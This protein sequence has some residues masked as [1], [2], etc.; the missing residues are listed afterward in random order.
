MP[1]PP[2]PPTPSSSVDPARSLGDP[3]P[4]PGGELTTLLL[5]VLRNVNREVQ[6]TPALDGR[7]QAAVAHFQAISASLRTLADGPP[8]AFRNAPTGAASRLP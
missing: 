8:A 3:A 4:S 2:I 7:A 5:E 1:T 6:A